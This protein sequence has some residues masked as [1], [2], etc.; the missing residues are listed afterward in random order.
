MKKKGFTLVELLAVIAILAILVIVALPNVMG[1]FNSAKLSSFETEL[2]NILGA[3][4]QQYMQDQISMLGGSN[5]ISVLYSRV[6]PLT[7][8]DTSTSG[9]VKCGDNKEVDLQGREILKYV[10]VFNQ[11]GKVTRFVANDG[12]FQY[13]SGT[14]TS[15]DNF[16]AQDITLTKENNTVSEITD[17]S[18]LFNLYCDNNGKVRKVSGTYNASTNAGDIIQ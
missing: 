10:I 11:S 6:A 12:T 18:T 17:T 16:S 1:M 4:Q 13:D 14:K 3:A 9:G 5:N 8:A 2:K 7:K 15:S